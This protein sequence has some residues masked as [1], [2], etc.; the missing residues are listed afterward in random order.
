[1]HLAKNRHPRNFLKGALVRRTP[2]SLAAKSKTTCLL[3]RATKA[4]ALALLTTFATGCKSFLDQS[5]LTRGPRA[6]RLVVPILSSID[7]ID[8]AE[9]E[10]PGATDL[11]PE[12]LKVSAVD[13]RI[14]PGDLVTVSVY[15]LVQGGVESMRS[16]RVSETGMLSLPLLGDPIRGSGLTEAQLQRAI[17]DRYREA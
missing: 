12:D 13:Y 15:D 2:S 17:A 14:T 7:P 11:R 4:V 6:E 1:M 5:E 10:F 16:A 9:T 3:S 8:Q